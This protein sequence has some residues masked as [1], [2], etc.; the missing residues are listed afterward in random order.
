MKLGQ[1]D[2]ERC[3]RHLGYVNY[4]GIDEGDWRRLEEAMDSIPSDYIVGYIKDLLDRLD[5]TWD[6]VNLVTSKGISVAE[7][8]AG[9]IN[10]TVI[11]EDTK[12]KQAT[13]QREYDRLVEELATTLYVT[14]YRHPNMQPRRERCAVSVLAVPGPADT[15]VSSRRLEYVQLGGGIGF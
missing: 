13:W 5:D 3:K 12:E 7:T 8:Y 11:R 4:E 14:N 1:L 10:R 6:N 9:D 2:R 15:S